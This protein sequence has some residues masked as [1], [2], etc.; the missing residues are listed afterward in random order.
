MHIRY[1]SLSLAKKSVAY[2]ECAAEFVEDTDTPENSYYRPIID[3]HI[4]DANGSQIGQW[5]VLE[6]DSDTAPT[7]FIVKVINIPPPSPGNPTPVP[8]DSVHVDCAK[9]GTHMG[10]GFNEAHNKLRVR[11]GVGRELRM[12]NNGDV[13][14]PGE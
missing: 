12:M 2:Y 3:R 6:Q 11:F 1:W 9:T 14:L 10:K 5:S 8:A 7:S 13:I 4:A